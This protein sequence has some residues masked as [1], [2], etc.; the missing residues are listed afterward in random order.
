MKLWRSML[1]MLLCSGLIIAFGLTACGDDDDE[2]SGMTCDEALATLTSD[3][4]V[5]AIEAALPGVQACLDVC[6]I[7]DED[8]VD[9]C[10]TLEGV[11]PSS[12]IQA[13]DM[14]L[15]TEEAV[16]GSCYVNCGQS[17]VNCL[18]LG[19]PPDTCLVQLGAC[20]PLCN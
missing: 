2:E 7:G 1:A 16:C 11:L 13:I 15:D 3:T 5:D 9:E 14:L 4:C 18:V 20:L 12:C 10:L 6:P 8:C 19:T 17:L